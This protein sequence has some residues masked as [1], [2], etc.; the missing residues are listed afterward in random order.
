MPD[1]LTLRALPGIPLMSGSGGLPDQLCMALQRV[2]GP[3]DG[4]VLVVTQKVVSKSEGCYVCLD[5]VVPSERARSLSSQCGKPP[6]Y[7]EVVLQ[8]SEEVLR[9][10]PGVLIVRHR[11]GHVM[12]NAGIDQSNVCTSGASTR[13]LLLPRDPD[14]SARRLREAVRQ[15]FDVSVAVLISD[16]FGR[17]WRLGTCGVC[18]GAAGLQPVLDLRGQPDLFGRPLEISQQAVAD[19]LASAAALLMGQG[20][21]GLPIVLVRGFSPIGDGC[22]GDLLRRPEEDLFR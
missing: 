15:R 11:N 18:I 1:T 5:E 19:E 21:E 9:C 4:D 20:A 14:A 2:G 13:V 22:A 17:P 8:E 10:A 12:A 3:L 6:A 16:S 7:V